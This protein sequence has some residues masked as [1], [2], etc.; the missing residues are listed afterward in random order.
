MTPRKQLNPYWSIQRNR[1]KHDVILFFF[2][3]M[4]VDSKN[5][6][7]AKIGFHFRWSVAEIF[8]FLLFTWGH[9]RSPWVKG[10]ICCL[11]KLSFGVS[12]VWL[13]Y[14]TWLTCVLVSWWLYRVFC[15][16][17]WCN[18]PATTRAAVWVY[19]HAGIGR[20]KAG[21]SVLDSSVA[22]SESNRRTKP[23]SLHL[24]LCVTALSD[25]SWERCLGW[26]WLDSFSH[27]RDGVSVWEESCVGRTTSC[28][29]SCS[30]SSSPLLL[31]WATA[32]FPANITCQWLVYHTPTHQQAAD[33]IY[34]CKH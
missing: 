1:E 18:A 2:L 10:D 17:R 19:S 16:L 15:F 26:F 34:S 32:L 8:H 24:E 3:H 13:P 5:A 9:S 6:S 21:E 4:L 20:H 29:P 30:S 12:G 27:L 31:Q 22:E 11:K 23:E 7:H 14:I 25:F 28:F 33:I